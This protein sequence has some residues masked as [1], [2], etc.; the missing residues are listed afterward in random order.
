MTMTTLQEKQLGVLSAKVGDTPMAVI[1][2]LVHG[3]P[4][5]VFLKLEGCN[6][7]GSS[8]DRTARALIE[9]AEARGR[10]SPR[11]IVLE[12]TS[13][14]LGVA[15]SIICVAK[16][17]P[18][19]AVVD[20]KITEENLA[21]M[22]SM[23]ARIEMVTKRDDTG[24]YLSSRLARVHEL[25]ASSPQYLWLDQYSNTA[26]PSIHCATTGPEI[27]RQMNGKV[28][29]LFVAVST[30]GTLAGVAQYFRKV[31]PR[32]TIIA[33]D[34]RGS[35]ALGGS[36][37]CRRLTGIGSTQVSAF[38]QKWHYD[39]ACLVGDEAAFSYCRTLSSKTRLKVGGSSGA[40]LAACAHYLESHPEIENVVCL[41]P[42][43]GENY[44]T[45]IF[46]DRWLEEAEIT[47]QDCPAIQAARATLNASLT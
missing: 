2:L 7:G 19:V 31:S 9:D 20:P 28:G 38:I 44:D 40:V 15:L 47:L 12:S 45:T 24:G 43:R 46:N 34:A 36:A 4:T 39:H 16:G 5:K 21:R 25:R 17:Y 1:T 32:T 41:C 3:K 8:K 22:R 37:G 23:E 6:P 26:N 11:S 27:Y 14:N 35:V 13:G 30:G 33:V 42:D 10:L 29:V 18:F